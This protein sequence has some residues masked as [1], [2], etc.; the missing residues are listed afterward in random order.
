VPGERTAPAVGA[1]SVTR[2]ERGTIV[3]PQTADRLMRILA[4]HPE[5]LAEVGA[6][7]GSGGAV[8]VRESRGP[9]RK[10]RKRDA[11]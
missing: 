10:S 2:W 6:H 7:A 3:Q 5:L 9:Y 11:S 8:V 1:K 4:A